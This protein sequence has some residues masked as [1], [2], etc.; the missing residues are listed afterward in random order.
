MP[1][2][3]ERGHIFI[4][5]PPLYRVKKGKQ[6][7]YV[8]DDKALDEY[9]THIA[10]DG[11]ELYVN[12]SAPAITGASLEKIISDLGGIPTKRLIKK[13]D[14]L[15]VGDNVFVAKG[16]YLYKGSPLK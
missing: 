3:I 14:Y 1:E 6:I 2:L 11:A 15:I 7:N 12:R 4:S 8:K 13:T 5:Q 16:L 9:L 10:I